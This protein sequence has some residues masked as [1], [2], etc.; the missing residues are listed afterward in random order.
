METEARNSLVERLAGLI[1]PS[2]SRRAG[3][4]KSLRTV[5]LGGA[6]SVQA[7]GSLVLMHDILH[8]LY[9]R[10]L[11]WGGPG[12]EHEF[13]DKAMDKGSI[14]GMW[15]SSC[16]F[17]QLEQFFLPFGDFHPHKLSVVLLEAH[18]CT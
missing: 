18:R 16:Y 5:P 14:S 13:V 15:L 4:V 10:I 8:R 1:M 12:E 3:R 7:V 11:D 2:P 6:L 17:C 9:Q